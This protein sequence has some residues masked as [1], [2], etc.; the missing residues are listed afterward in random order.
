M[1][2]CTQ[3]PG[4]D[5]RFGN[6]ERHSLGVRIPG[7]QRYRGQYGHGPIKQPYGGRSRHGD[8]DPL[9]G[10]FAQRAHQQVKR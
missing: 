2:S 6:S 3:R 9:A 8:Q 7:W 5:G 10:V 1:A 4:E